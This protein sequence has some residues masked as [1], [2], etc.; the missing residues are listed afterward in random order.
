[1]IIEFKG[2]EDLDN[3]KEFSK[4]KNQLFAYS[5]QEKVYRKGFRQI[6]ILFSESKNMARGV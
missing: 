6:L 3:E 4:A 1:M 5:E 2:N